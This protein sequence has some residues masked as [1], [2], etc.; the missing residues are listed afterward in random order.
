MR[1][2]IQWIDNQGR[3]TPDQNPA[4]GEVWM[5]K[6]VYQR[7]DGTGVLIDD[8]RRWPICAAHAK[9]LTETGMH[10]WSFR[11]YPSA[12]LRARYAWHRANPSR[13]CEVGFAAKIAYDRAKAE[14]WANAHE[15]V[16][17]WVMGDER[18]E[19]SAIAYAAT[20]RVLA[21]IGGY[22][23]ADVDNRASEA[24]VLVEAKAWCDDLVN[25]GFTFAE[26]G[27]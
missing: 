6:R 12:E 21:A 24:Q 4:I 16:V 18:G 20:G 23:W 27:S 9:Q 17:N 19:Y 26:I 8:P 14:L 22:E 5:P 1:C 7:A 13:A 11:P 3:P 15:V 10:I 25:H 2:R